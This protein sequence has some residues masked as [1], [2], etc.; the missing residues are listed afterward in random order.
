MLH[1][2]VSNLALHCL[3]M[4][5]LW[6]V[7]LKWVNPLMPC[8]FFY[9]MIWTTQFPFLKRCLVEMAMFNIQRAVIPTVGK[10]SYGSCVLHFDLWCFTFG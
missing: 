3:P 6:D 7:R 8:G 9:L 5:L 4:S 2:G 1:S 10:Q